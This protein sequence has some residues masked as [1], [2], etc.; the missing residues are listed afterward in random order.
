MGVAYLFWGT[1]TWLFSSQKETSKTEDNSP[2]EQLK[3]FKNS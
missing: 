2:E 1:A 3:D